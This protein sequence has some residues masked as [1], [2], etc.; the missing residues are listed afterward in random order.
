MKGKNESGDEYMTGEEKIKKRNSRDTLCS[1][2][3][4]GS[5]VRTIG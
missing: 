1:L 3:Y 2:D 4:P 5:S